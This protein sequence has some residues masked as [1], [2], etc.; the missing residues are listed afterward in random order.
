MDSFSRYCL[1]GNLR[2]LNNVLKTAAVI[3][4]SDREITTAH[5]ADDFKEELAALGPPTLVKTG[6]A[7]AAKASALP[8]R[9]LAAGQFS[10][11]WDLANLTASKTAPVNSLEQVEITTIMRVLSACAGNVSLASKQLNISRNTIYRKLNRQP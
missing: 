9:P 11:T 4:M 7:D 5:L 3:A 6:A 2:Q 10:N 8:A 1:P